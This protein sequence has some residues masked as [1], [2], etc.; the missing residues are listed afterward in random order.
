MVAAAATAA[1]NTL[2]FADELDLDAVTPQMSE[3]FAR[4]YP[5]Q[6]LEDRLNALG[7]LSPGS[8]AVQ[9][10]LNG[11]KGVYH[12]VL[13]RDRLNEGGQV[14]GLVLGEGQHAELPPEQN[15]PGFD[16][17]IRNEDGS[18]DTV[19]QAKATEGAR[20]IHDA[21][22][23]Y[24]DIDIVATDEGA[25]RVIDDRVAASGF[26]DEDLE[27]RVASPMAELWDGPV[28][29]FMETVLP[30]LPFVIIGATEGA[31]VLMGRQAFESAVTASAQRSAKSAA[32]M[33][34]GM[35]AALAGAGFLSLPVTLATRV[36]IDRVQVHT[37]LASKIKHDREA[38]AALPRI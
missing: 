1:L 6:D 9:G 21:L 23:R 28:E 7:D 36:G 16:L 15:T 34:A 11:W 20:L 19:L 8:S 2:L 27:D 10:F 26:S 4:A 38:L 5:G 24:P 25:A 31:K 32:A 35:L 29:E 3:A 17:I 12:E 22:E 37:R 18:V 13:I 14:G 30:G 33:G